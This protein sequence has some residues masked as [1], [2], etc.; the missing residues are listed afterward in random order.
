MRVNQLS[1]NAQRQIKIMPG[2]PVFPTGRTVFLFILMSEKP[3]QRLKSLFCNKQ[4][5]SEWLQIKKYQSP[6]SGE[7]S[8]LHAGSQESLCY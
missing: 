6:D 1:L 4:K 3:Y 5:L 8:T 2:A 7:I